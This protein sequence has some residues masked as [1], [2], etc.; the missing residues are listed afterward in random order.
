MYSEEIAIYSGMH[1]IAQLIRCYKSCLLQCPAQAQRT[2]HFKARY[3]AF[4]I[5][6]MTFRNHNTVPEFFADFTGFW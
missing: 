5:L 1:V 2:V 6:D 3:I 4:V